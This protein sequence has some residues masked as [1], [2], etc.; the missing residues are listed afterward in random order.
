[1][2]IYELTWLLMHGEI[3]RIM[4]TYKHLLLDVNVLTMRKYN[5]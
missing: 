1:M 5:E 4:A 2:R 3:G